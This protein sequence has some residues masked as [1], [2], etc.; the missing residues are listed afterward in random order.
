M[1]LMLD[2]TAMWVLDAQYRHSTSPDYD[3]DYRRQLSQSLLSFVLVFFKATIDRRNLH[4][5]L[6][7]VS[8]RL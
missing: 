4:E 2:V 1:L 7:C 6:A 5:K 3:V 8:Y